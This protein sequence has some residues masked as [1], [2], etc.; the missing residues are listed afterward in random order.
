MTEKSEETN[1]DGNE[2]NV[3]RDT[4]E[5]NEQKSRKIHKKEIS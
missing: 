2:Y 1:Q 4:L 5:R 3:G